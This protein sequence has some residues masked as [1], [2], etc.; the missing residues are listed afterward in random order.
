MQRTSQACRPASRSARPPPSPAR[1][2]ALPPSA[3]AR[4]RRHDAKSDPICSPQPV[5]AEESTAAQNEGPARGYQ[6][7]LQATGGVTVR[8]WPHGRPARLYVCAP[9]P[10]RL[11]HPHLPPIAT[12]NR[13]SGVISLVCTGQ[14]P[15]LAEFAGQRGRGASA[16]RR[17]PFRLA[18]QHQPGLGEASPAPGR[19]RADVVK[20]TFDSPRSRARAG[21]LSKRP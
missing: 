8:L 12:G 3:S 20:K 16:T 2:V 19:R 10:A 15:A 17:S 13:P 1:A 6:E 7:L 4:S 5:L 21:V 11:S 14:P 18:A 9:P